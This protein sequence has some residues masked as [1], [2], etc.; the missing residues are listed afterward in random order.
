M[1]SPTKFMVAVVQLDVLGIS[2]WRA[3]CM[4]C[5]WQGKPREREAKALTDAKA[6][7]AEHAAAAEK[8]PSK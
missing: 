5:E 8:E 3:K 1:S 2:S 6:H 7:G 4:H